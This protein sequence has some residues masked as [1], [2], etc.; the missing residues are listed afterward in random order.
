M[1]ESWR[2]LFPNNDG[3]PDLLDTIQAKPWSESNWGFG[4][5]A[6]L[7]FPTRK[8]ANHFSTYQGLSFVANDNP[9]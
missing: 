2:L 1:A 7:N 6:D 4:R 3:S 8:S 5:S 9:W